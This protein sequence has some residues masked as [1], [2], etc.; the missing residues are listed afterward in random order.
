MA[1][2]FALALAILLVPALLPGQKPTSPPTLDQALALTQVWLSTQRAYEDIPGMSVAIVHDQDRVWSGGF[3]EADPSNGRAATD[4]TLYSICSVSKLFTA[5]GVMQL[6]D[7]GKLRLD[8][9]IGKHLP[10]FTLKPA[11]RG[12]PVTVEG[13]LTHSAGLPR[14]ADYPYWTGEFRFPTHEQIVERIASQEALYPASTYF[15]YS[16]LGL[17]LAGELIANA[18]GQ[19]YDEYVRR[20]VL[21]PLGLRNTFTEMPESERGKRL[22]QGFSAE[23]R[24]GTRKPVPFFTARGIAPAAGFASTV[25]DLARFASWQFRLLEKGGTEVVSVHTL[26]EMHRPHWVDP[27]FELFWGLGFSVRKEGDSVVV[28]H[29]GSCPGFRTA[30]TLVPKDEI[31][32]VVMANASGVDTGKYA[33]SIR[34]IVGPTIAK[35]P[36]EDAPEKKTA[37]PPTLEAYV[38]SYDVF[39]WGGEMLVFVWGD[40][41]GVI[42]VPSMDPIERMELL[43]KTGEHTFRRVRKDDA[44]GETVVFEMGPDG[45]PTALR[46][47]SNVYPRM[48]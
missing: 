34:K 17:S 31:A 40:H 48:P 14:E 45:R 12:A 24:D 47:H 16:N 38:G 35:K 13:L 15:Q 8:D 46:Q 4:E 25:N 10:W 29:G 18:S 26:R 11:E 5:I 21:D 43:R 20:N 39:P 37:P 27:D 6:R 22:A 44:L 7:A 41:L 9:P 23:R 42:D 1:R 28:G 32:V 2:V 3:G 30:L 33:S 36:G 19:P